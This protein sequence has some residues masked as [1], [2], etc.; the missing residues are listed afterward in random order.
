LSL[1]A[2]TPGAREAI[3]RIYLKEFEETVADENEWGG[4][5]AMINSGTSQD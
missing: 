4:V 3:L 2:I 5:V 1:L